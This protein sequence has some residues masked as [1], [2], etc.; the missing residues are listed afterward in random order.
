VKGG[1]ADLQSLLVGGG[2]IDPAGFEACL[3]RANDAELPLVDA[4]IQETELTEERLESMKKEAVESAVFEMFGWASGDFSFD[5][6]SGTEAED[7]KLIL[8]VGANA[9]YLAMEGMRLLDEGSRDSREAAA[10][11]AITETAAGASASPGAESTQAGTTA[12]MDSSEAAFQSLFGDDPLETDE[13]ESATANADPMDSFAELD[14][15]TDSSLDTDSPLD[16]AGANADDAEEPTAADVI[17]ARAIEREAPAGI[18]HSA[19]DLERIR[20]QPV[21][22]IEPEVSGLEWVKATIGSGFARVHVFQ[23]AEQG[24]AR[25]RQYMIRGQFPVVLIS[26]ATEIDPLSGIHGIG[27]FVKRLKSQAPRIRVIGIRESAD[28]GESPKEAPIAALDAV[29]ERPSQRQTREWSGEENARARAAFSTTLQAKLSQPIQS[30][31]KPNVVEAKSEVERQRAMTE[32]MQA[33]SSRGE[34]LPVVLEFASEKF[35]RAAILVARD[36]EIFAVAGHGIAALEVDPLGASQSVSVPAHEEG[37]IRRVVESGQAVGAPPST[38]A[39]R[40]LLKRFGG[41]VPAAAYLGPIT[42]GGGVVAVL[43]GDMGETGQP[44]PEASSLEVVLHHA[45]VALDRAALERARLEA[46]DSGA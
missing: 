35:A 34:I 26:T 1:A 44:L 4:L 43:Y 27:D 19:A 32:K 28:E 21:V 29:M 37:W 17:A 31:S 16:A 46:E 20:N 10:T 42:S 38:E 5:V 24:L 33:A 8:Q 45:G 9:Q 14:L 12:E 41:I 7:P 13:F 22:L 25:I 30:A 15:D 36:Q 6:R 2:L 40:I 23:K 39:D 3:A 18:E 11:E